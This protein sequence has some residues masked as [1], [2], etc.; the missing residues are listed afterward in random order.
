[1][2]RGNAGE[3]I[4]VFKRFNINRRT[5]LTGG[6]LAAAGTVAGGLGLR[7]WAKTPINNG[8]DV[9]NEEPET[10]A[11]LA[12][13]DVSRIRLLQFTD[14]HF[15]CQWFRPKKDQQ[16]VDELRR[17]V[18]RYEPHVVMATGDLWHDNPLGRGEEFMTYAIEQLEGLGV[19]WLFTW[20]NHD[21]LNDYTVGH[22]AM[23]RAKN[24]LYRGGPGGGCYT[25]SLTDREGAARWDLV[26][27]NSMDDGL[28]E[29][30]RAWLRAEKRRREAEPGAPNA[31]GIF[32]IPVKQYDTIWGEEEASGVKFEQVCYWG[33]DGSSFQHIK[34]LGTVRACFVGHDHVNDYSGLYDGIE[35]VYGRAT[36]QA[37]YGGD[38]VPKGAKLITANAETGQYTWQSVYVDGKHWTPEPGKQ[39]DTYRDD[40]WTAPV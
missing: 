21:Q 1:M 35:L 29:P 7:A 37:G 36:G 15:F 13:D 17:Y 19:P 12:V 6:A 39:I 38:K 34:A 25:V 4:P 24:S 20:G 5:F 30:Q 10:Q 28:M 31:F 26:C 2:L 18:D 23:T 22:A 14:V 32:H 9:W 8:L 11:T 40:L 3:G 16:T 27:L 33:E